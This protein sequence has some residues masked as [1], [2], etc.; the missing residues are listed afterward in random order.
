MEAYS[1]GGKE[2]NVCRVLILLAMA[3]KAAAAPSDTLV[4]FPQWFVSTWSIGG[5]KLGGS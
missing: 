1:L 2:G 3:T 5:W 4:F